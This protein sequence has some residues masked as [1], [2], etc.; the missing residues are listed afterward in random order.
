MAKS[1]LFCLIPILVLFYIANDFNNLIL[2]ANQLSSLNRSTAFSSGTAVAFPLPEWA[3]KGERREL[4]FV[5]H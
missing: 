3:I 4:C 5:C 2:E 1:R